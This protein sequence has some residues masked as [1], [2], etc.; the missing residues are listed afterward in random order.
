MQIPPNF[1]LKEASLADV[2]G[3]FKLLDG[4]AKE[5]LLLFKSKEQIAEQISSFRV[6]AE[7]NS[8]SMILACAQLDIFTEYLAEVKSLAVDTAFQK[9]GLG[10]SLVENCEKEAK[11]LN[12]KSIFAL[13]YQVKFFEKLGF[14]L[15][16]I[17]SLPEK[18]FKE[19]V[20]CPFY[21]ACNENA[22]L[23]QL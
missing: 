13:T 18:V 14:H 7:S 17:E 1:I 5:R 9:H 10:R 20:V 23:K 19:C 8:E 16:D 4:F 22:M 21:G 12:I 15:V 3:I 11:A 6:I 2:E